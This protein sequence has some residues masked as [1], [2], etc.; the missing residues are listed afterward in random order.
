MRACPHCECGST[1]HIEAKLQTQMSYVSGKGLLFIE[2]LQDTPCYFVT[3]SNELTYPRSSSTACS[4]SSEGP[5]PAMTLMPASATPAFSTSILPEEKGCHSGSPRNFKN[6]LCP[7]P[8]TSL[9]G[10]MHNRIRAKQYKAGRAV[11]IADISSPAS[12]PCPSSLQVSQR[13]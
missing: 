9:H 8:T 4:C 11:P 1:S 3:R 2:Y 12:P 6:A 13:L 5:N 7:R 10:Q